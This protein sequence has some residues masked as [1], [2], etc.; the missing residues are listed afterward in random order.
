MRKDPLRTDDEPGRPPALKR[1]LTLPLLTLYGLGV[2]IGAGIYVL[3]GATAAKAGVYAPISF[4][5]A[6]GVVGF[7]GFSYCELGSRYPVSGGEAA[8]VREGFNSRTL[9]L[10]VGLMVVASGVVSSSAIVIG[11]A[12]YLQAFVPLSPAILTALVILLIGL[13]AVWGIL[14]SVTLA[15]LFTVIEIGGL[16]LVVYFGLMSRPSALAEIGSLF[17]PFEMHAWRGILAAG[18][19]AFFAFVGFEDMANVAE[20]VKEPRKTLPRGIILTLIIA[21]LIY[22]IVVSVVVLV[23]PMNTL[24]GSTAPLAL[25]FEDAGPATSGLFN[26]IAAIATINGALIQV[27]MASRVLYGLAAQGSLPRIL[28]KVNPVTQTPLPATALVIVIIF[29]LAYFL[30][31]VELAETTSTIVLT[32]F[33]LVNLALLRLKWTGHTASSEAFNVPVWVPIMGF[34]SSGLLLLAGFAFD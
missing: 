21:T 26:I 1:G 14:E 12:S 9:S 7:T 27:I 5:L 4:L 17:P 13:V 16:G 34:I 18:L 30:P 15:A 6:A 32:V 19:L 8:Y 11:A 31:I 22:F 23:V 29:I 28:A 25:I 20:E 10:I 24:Q 2:T 3:V 33:V